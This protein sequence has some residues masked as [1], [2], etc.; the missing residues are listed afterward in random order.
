MLDLLCSAAVFCVL[1]FGWCMTAS[2]GLS[3]AVIL[4]DGEFHESTLRRALSYTVVLAIIFGAGMLV[5]G[6]VVGLWDVLL[7]VRERGANQ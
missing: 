5:L 2:L 6:G 4:T 7:V 1:M 3:A